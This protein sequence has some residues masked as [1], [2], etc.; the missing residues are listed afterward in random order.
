MSL[1]NQGYQGDKG[2]ERE[3]LNG[4]DEAFEERFG[5]G[6]KKGVRQL[7]GKTLQPKLDG[8]DVDGENRN[9]YNPVVWL[10]ESFMKGAAW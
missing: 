2:D 1:R 5:V 7:A 8:K 10:T 6:G 9:T 4:A 3:R